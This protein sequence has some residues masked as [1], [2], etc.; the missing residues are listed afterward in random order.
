[1]KSLLELSLDIMASV[2]SISLVISL[3]CKLWMSNDYD[4]LLNKIIGTS[5][6]LLIASVFFFGLWCYRPKS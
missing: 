5:I 1:M 4:V 2:S 6:I 3:V